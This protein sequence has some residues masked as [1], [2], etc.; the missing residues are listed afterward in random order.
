MKNKIISLVMLSMILTSCNYGP[1]DVKEY[2]TDLEFK[3]NYTICVIN[4]LHLSYNS[5]TSVQF[6]YFKDCVYARALVDHPN[7]DFNNPSNVE[8]LASYAPDLI[9]FN[10]DTFMSANKQ[11]VDSFFEYV[12]K[13]NIKFGIA[14][15]NHDLEGLY[16][17]MYID[18]VLKNCKNSIYKNP[19][20]DDVY[21][22]SN[23]VINLKDG[24]DVKWQ[25]IAMDTN[26]YINNGYDIIH[27]DQIAWYEKQVID[28]GN[29]PS[30]LITHIPINEYKKAWSLETDGNFDP[31]PSE[32]YNGDSIWWMNE[33]P[34]VSGVENHF[35]EKIQE[36]GSTQGIISGHDHLNVCDFRYRGE[37]T[38]EV[39]LI[40][41][42]KAGESIYH[43]DR[44]M[45]CSF[46]TLSDSNTF[47]NTRVFLNYEREAFIMTDKYLMT[48][49]RER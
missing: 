1:R 23:Y 34:N 44:I 5:N 20:N 12:D 48:E 11:V 40:N 31:V 8:I 10:G 2:Q 9:M 13:L 37:G 17:K 6:K 33:D 46:Y 18:S 7:L 28:G 32:D 35:F 24:D 36:L 42:P 27:D 41:G 38:H 14:Y 19:L 4:D 15:G 29:A 3:S 43:D 39:R 25:I 21:G 49:G 26:T 30:L 47:E 45:G 16:G 22:N